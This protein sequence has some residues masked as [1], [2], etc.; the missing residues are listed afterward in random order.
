MRYKNIISCGAYIVAITLLI[1]LIIITSIIVNK[2][3]QPLE[4]SPSGWS[5]LP[6]RCL[7]NNLACGS[8]LSGIGRR[9]KH[10]RKKHH[11]MTVIQQQCNSSQWWLWKTVIDRSNKNI[12]FFYNN[13][14]TV[15]NKQKN[16]VQG[17][18]LPCMHAAIGWLNSFWAVSQSI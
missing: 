12:I 7:T 10:E 5:V 6:R 17:N 16:V 1:I 3:P 4:M 2:V 8:V 18:T 9:N 14:C 11:W 15:Q 13:T